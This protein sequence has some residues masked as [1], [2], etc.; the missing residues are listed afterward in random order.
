MKMGH[1]NVILINLILLTGHMFLFHVGAAIFILLCPC[2]LIGDKTGNRRV[3]DIAKGEN[4]PP[5][6]RVVPIYFHQCQVILVSGSTD[7][8]GIMLTLWVDPLMYS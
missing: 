2:F 1:I 5:P 8:A 6:P 3:P 4:I 7:V